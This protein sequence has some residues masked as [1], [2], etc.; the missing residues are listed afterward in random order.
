MI[1]IAS[2]KRYKENLKEKHISNAKYGWY[3]YDTKFAL[4]VYNEKQVLE[5]FNVFSAVLLIRHAHN[6][7]LYLYDLVNI[8][9]KRVSRLS[10]S[11]TV[12][13]SLLFVTILYAFFRNVNHKFRL[14]SL[15]TSRKL[16]PLPAP[17]F[18]YTSKVS[19]P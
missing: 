11:C 15:K 16:Q 17:F 14:I 4:P 18:S 6:G 8:K 19:S 3:R 9:K 13:N 7:K 5:R 1:A 12:R 2:Q 10:N